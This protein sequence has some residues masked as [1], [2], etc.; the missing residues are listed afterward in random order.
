MS[1]APPPKAVVVVVGAAVAAVVG[2]AVGAVV[3]ASVGA[4]VSE[5]TVDETSVKTVDEADSSL[6]PPRTRSGIAIASAMM[7]KPAAAMPI[8]K[9]VRFR[10]DGGGEAG[11]PGGMYCARDFEGVPPVSAAGVA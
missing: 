8:H 3:G 5:T 1:P 9:A 2:A 10:P 11:C 7:I 4:V 6:P